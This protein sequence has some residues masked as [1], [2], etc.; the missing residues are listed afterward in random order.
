MRYHIYV[1]SEEGDIR[2]CKSVN[3]KESVDALLSELR[4][5]GF[6]CEYLAW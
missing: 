4:S 1:W 2:Y 5:I 6:G 3:T